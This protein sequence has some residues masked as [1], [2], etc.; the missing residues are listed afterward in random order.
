MYLAT[1][2]VFG[3]ICGAFE[4]LFGRVMDVIATFAPLCCIT[5]VLNKPTD[6]PAWKVVNRNRRALTKEFRAEMLK[7]KKESSPTDNEPF[8]PAAD[9]LEIKLVDVVYAHPGASPIF[10]NITFTCK[11]GSICAIKSEPGRGRRSLMELIAHKMFPNS[12]TLFIPSHLRILYVSADS[13]LLNLSLWQN[14]TFGNAKGNNPY[15]VENILKALDMHEALELCRRDL[16]ARKKA[17][18]GAGD[19]QEKTEEEEEEEIEKVNPLDKWRSSQKANVHLARAL[20]MNPELMV[21]HRPFMNYPNKKQSDHIATI[22]KEHRDTR[23]FQMDP[24]QKHTRRPR[25]MFFT[26]DTPEEAEIADQCWVLPTEVGGNCWS[27]L[28]V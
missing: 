4:S 13:V 9:L 16:T 15:R 7:K 25:T 23:G 21:L 5:Y 11:Q 12:G 22:L 24:S 17:F 26:P 19:E 2:S 10:Q 28:P 14:L 27:T 20:I 8:V 1:I 3:D 18:D 6:V